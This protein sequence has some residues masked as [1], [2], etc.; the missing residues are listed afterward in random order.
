MANQLWEE[1]LLALIG[2]GIDVAG[3]PGEICGAVLSVRYHDET[4]SVWNR[5]G[6]NDGVVAKIR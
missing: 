4:L 3:G 6:D 5:T 2:E 1:T